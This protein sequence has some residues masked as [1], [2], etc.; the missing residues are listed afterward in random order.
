[1]LT[2]KILRR[3]WRRRLAIAFTVLLAAL[4]SSA[5]V[6]RQPLSDDYPGPAELPESLLQEFSYTPELPVMEH[7]RVRNRLGVTVH[8]MQMPSPEFPDRSLQIEHFEPQAD[9][10]V[11]VIVIL[12]I[13]SG[14]LNVSRYF[15]RFFVNQGWAVLV[16]DR[17]R[18][19]LQEDILDPEE[20]IQSNIR[21]YMRLLDWVTAN[22]AFDPDRVGVFGVS[23]GGMD[24]VMLAAL[25]DRVSA[26]V[27][28]M[29]GGDLTYVVRN[30]SYRSINRRVEYVLS[31][32]GLAPEAFWHEMDQN[33]HTEP[34]M[35]APYVNAEDVLLVLT[36]SDW[37][38]PFEAQEDLLSS[39]GHPESL[40]LPTGHRTSVVYFPLLRNAAHDFF[41]RRFSAGQY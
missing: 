4:A 10:P 15:A 41:L 31:E 21:D 28:A 27:A 29:A 19:E 2:P 33:I 16:V 1:M 7:D 5:C 18:Q 6:T 3:G 24:A 25:D 35:L 11:P 23:L 37:I 8:E 14:Q 22:P 17:A 36:R 32:S 30:T 40:I 38:V 9:G 20:T 26:V 12:P 39:M 13:Y 34:A